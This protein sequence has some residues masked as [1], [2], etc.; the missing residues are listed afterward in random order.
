MAY[1]N[2][3]NEAAPA[4]SANA[5]TIDDI[6]RAHKLDIRERMNDVVVDWTADPVVIDVTGIGVRTGVDLY[7]SHEILHGEQDDD[8][9]SWIEAYF[10]SDDEERFVRGSVRLPLGAVVKEV[11]AIID[12]NAA[13]SVEL[14]LQRR[15]HST[16][17][18]VVPVANISTSSTGVFD[19]AA[20]G[21]NHTVVPGAYYIQFTNPGGGRFRVYGI[22]IRIDVAG[23]SAYI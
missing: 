4:G 2:V 20:L 17:P 8:D 23:L 3:W 19:L 14:R 10:Q 7:F 1:T 13:A 11:S 9:I 21:L 6:I 18:G 5:N 16:T 12:I 15:S 22:R